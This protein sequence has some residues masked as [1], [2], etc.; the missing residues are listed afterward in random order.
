MKKQTQEQ[1]ELILATGQTLQVKLKRSSRAK[2]LIFKIDPDSSF[3]LVAPEAFSL[4]RIR[5]DL[6]QFL[7]RIEKFLSK[8]PPKPA[9]C[10]PESI[11]ITV[12]QQEFQVKLIRNKTE[13]DA[14]LKKRAPLKPFLYHHAD[15][16]LLFDPDG[17]SGSWVRL[18]QKFF[19]Q[20]AKLELPRLF[21]VKARLLGYTDLKAVVRNQKTKLGSCAQSAAKPPVISLNWRALFLP[22]ALLEH[23]FCHELSH[24]EQMNHSKAFYETLENHSPNCRVKEKELNAAWANLPA[25]VR[26]HQ[27][28]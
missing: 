6:D 23:L 10:P 15:K 26:E 18:L 1:L 21:R 20:M 12:L 25:W 8:L 2:R 9:L 14:L 28:L 11:T 7:P 4:H 3:A 13:L 27:R 19:L 16:L 24:V 17:L 22:P 5:T